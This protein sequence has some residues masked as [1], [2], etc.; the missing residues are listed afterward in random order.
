MCQPRKRGRRGRRRD[1]A[2]PK[3]LNPLKPQFCEFAQR[4]GAWQQRLDTSKPLVVDVGSYNTKGGFAG[5]EVPKAVIPS[6]RPRPRSAD[7]PVAA[8]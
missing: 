4:W 6:V 8:G 5:D 2:V 1:G 3:Q 7:A